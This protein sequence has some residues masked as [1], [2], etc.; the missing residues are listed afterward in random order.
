MTEGGK[1]MT[2]PQPA[3]PARKR[4]N[5]SAS[6]SLLNREELA[7]SQP[8]ANSGKWLARGDFRLSRM[9]NEAGVIAGTGRAPGETD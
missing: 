1:D 5:P 9:L 4:R 3:G 2:Q 8:F 7:G 6:P